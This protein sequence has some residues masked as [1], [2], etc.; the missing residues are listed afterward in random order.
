MGATPS[1]VIRALVTECGRIVVV[2]LTVGLLGASA[3][4]R[5]QSALLFG[6]AANDVATYL[7]AVVLVAGGAL[8]ATLLPAARAGRTDPVAVMR[9]E[10]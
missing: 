4:A 1:G 10:G 5:V 6:V 8:I 2:G 9:S 3:F 7:A